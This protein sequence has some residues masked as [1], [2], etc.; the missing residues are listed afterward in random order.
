[1]SVSYAPTKYISPFIRYLS[2]EEVSLAFQALPGKLDVKYTHLVFSFWLLEPIFT[3]I[4]CVCELCH[5]AEG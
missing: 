5:Y 1:M 4:F 3:S 2:Y